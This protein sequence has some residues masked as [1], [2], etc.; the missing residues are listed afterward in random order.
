MPK[1]VPSWMRDASRVAVL[2]GAGAA[3]RGTGPA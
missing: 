3:A 2:T 1:L